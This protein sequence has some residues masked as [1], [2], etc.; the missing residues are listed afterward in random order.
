MRQVLPATRLSVN[1]RYGVRSKPSGFIS[2]H[3]APS[4]DHANAT[5]CDPRIIG[6][7]GIAAWRISETVTSDPVSGLVAGRVIP[8]LRRDGIRAWTVGF[9]RW[10]AHHKSPARQTLEHLRIILMGLDHG[11]ARGASRLSAEPRKVHDVLVK[12]QGQSVSPCARVIK[13]GCELLGNS[14]VCENASQA[15]RPSILRAWPRACCHI[16]IHT[17]VC[18]V[19]RVRARTWACFR[20][21]SQRRLWRSRYSFRCLERSSRRTGAED[22]VGDGGWEFRT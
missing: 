10:N 19:W 11:L 15:R 4:P 14:I 8:S 3:G 13:R 22:T 5:W 12:R 16:G 7:D 17:C 20:G 18:A 21:S 9:R 6:P 2:G 1:S